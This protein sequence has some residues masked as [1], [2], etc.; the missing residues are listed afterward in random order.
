MGVY[1]GYRL[2]ASAAMPPLLLEDNEAVTLAIGL[3]LTAS[4]PVAGLE[5]SAVRALTKVLQVM[6]PRLASGQGRGCRDGLRRRTSPSG[7]RAPSRNEVD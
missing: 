2:A 3:R 7:S 1:G 5:E 4:E 6:P